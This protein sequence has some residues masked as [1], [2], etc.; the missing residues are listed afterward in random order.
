M[1]PLCFPSLS[2]DPTIP[3]STLLHKL[4][5][6]GDVKAVVHTLHGGCTPHTPF[7]LPLPPSDVSATRGRA[8]LKKNRHR[9]L[10]RH[11]GVE[12]IV[13]QEA[14]LRWTPNPEPESGSASRA[15]VHISDSK[16][17]A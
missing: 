11:W 9:R 13:V 10:P 16:E 12:N 15:V 7:S 2:Y 1:M 17:Q 6:T 3:G 5:L 8:P 14:V 4:P